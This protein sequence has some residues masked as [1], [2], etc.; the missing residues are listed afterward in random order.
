MNH[1]IKVLKTIKISTIIIILMPPHLACY[2]HHHY[3]HRKNRHR[4][5][6]CGHTNSKCSIISI[7]N[8]KQQKQN[9]QHLCTSSIVLPAQFLDISPGLHKRLHCQSISIFR[10]RVQRAVSAAHQASRRVAIDSACAS[11]PFVC[12]CQA[13]SSIDHK[14]QTCASQT[15]HAAP[16]QRADVITCRSSRAQ[17]SAA[18]AYISGSPSA[19]SVDASCVTINPLHCRIFTAAVLRSTLPKTAT[20]CCRCFKKDSHCR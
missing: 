11:S 12:S 19:S 13:G 10:C 6:R 20:A 5:H 17:P 9:P 15:N 2:H 1:N 7:F 4:H 8:P 14:L 18:A 3:H 16:L